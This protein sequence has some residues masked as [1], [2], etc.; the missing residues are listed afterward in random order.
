MECFEKEKV[1]WISLRAPY[2][3]VSHGGGKT[4]LFYLKSFLEDGGFDITLLSFCYENEKGNA[5]YAHNNLKYDVSVIKKN[6]SLRTILGKMGMPASL[7]EYSYIKKEIVRKIK[8]CKHSGYYPKYVF[9]H[10]TEIVMLEKMIRQFFPD[11]IIIAIEED[12]TF[13][14]LE[15]KEKTAIGIKKIIYSIQR[16]ILKQK[17]LDSLKES[18]LVVLNNKK[19]LKLVIENGVEASKCISS[20]PF[21]EDMSHVRRKSE[22]GTLL[23]WGAMNR[24]E[25]IEAVKWF[26]NNVLSKVEETKLIV[27]G[28][29]PPDE[30]KQ[31]ESPSVVVTGFVDDPTPFFEN[32]MCMVVPLLSGAGIKI[33][34]LEGMSAGIPV[35]T[36]TIGIEGI[37]AIHMESYI[38]CETSEEY[39]EWIKRLMEDEK[40]VHSIGEWAKM[41]IKNSYNLGSDIKDL[42]EQIK[43]IDYE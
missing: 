36:N 20:V 22:C 24:P 19:D 7:L 11:S 1:L 27:L 6:E 39:C 9:L 14:K 15:R 37:E 5:K 42:I 23:Y 41:N 10:W 31:L 38:H 16:L 40:L 18:N 30:I 13:L 43:G 3:K 12:V 28:A 33:K 17:E 4:H 2:E 25:N 29:N 8:E 32:C 21:F 35:L 34:V 26:V